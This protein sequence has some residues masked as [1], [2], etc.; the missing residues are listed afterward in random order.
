[1]ASYENY[2]MKMAAME[3]AGEVMSL[4]QSLM[5]SP[6]C[7]WNEK[8][9]VMADV[10]KDIQ[11][12]SLYLLY[13]G[14]TLVAAAF[15]G[16]TDEFEHLTFWDPSVKRPCDLARIGVRKEYQNRG[17]AKE[18]I[19]RME[20]DVAR[21]GFDGIQLLVCKTNP[22][23]EAVYQAAGF[24]YCGETEIYDHEWNCYE[25]KVGPAGEA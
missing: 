20:R 12:E 14:P 19:R 1:M 11:N 9:P 16:A 13:D 21:R 24:R 3:Q 25:K 23:A 4:Y 8:Y 22:K 7:T 17:I 2:Q 6:G 18:L 10:E 15:M 5:G